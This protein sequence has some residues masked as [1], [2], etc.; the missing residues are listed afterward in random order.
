M[1]ADSLGLA[2]AYLLFGLL[3]G[4]LG[5]KGRAEDWDESLLAAVLGPPLL[6]LI[7]AAVVGRFVW[8]RLHAMLGDPDR[9][10]S[11]EQPAD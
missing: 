4:F 1:L 11:A 8:V 9:A 2:V 5:R 3:A 7:T 6:A 10:G